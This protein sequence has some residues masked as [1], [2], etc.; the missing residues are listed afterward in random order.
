[1]LDVDIPKNE[2]DDTLR[3][4]GFGYKMPKD[5]RAAT[6]EEFEAAAARVMEK[7]AKAFEELAKYD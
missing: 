7:Y 1:M 6:E 4:L 5:S 3:S 2:L